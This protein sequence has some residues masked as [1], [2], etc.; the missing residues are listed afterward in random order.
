[1]HI[2]SNKHSTNQQHEEPI[3]AELIALKTNPVP[4]VTTPAA[5]L[6][7][8]NADQSQTSNGVIELTA[9]RSSVPSIDPT[10]SHPQLDDSILAYIDQSL[11]KIKEVGNVSQSVPTT[12]LTPPIHGADRHFHHHGSNNELH[13]LYEMQRRSPYYDSSMDRVM[14][15]Q[16]VVCLF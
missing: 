15:N 14:F 8:P 10:P 2:S 1:M 11:R 6:P 7:V 5:L 12:A 16:S 3:E 4:I 9:N 13:E